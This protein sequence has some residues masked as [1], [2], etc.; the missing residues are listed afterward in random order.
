MWWGHGAT[1]R[2]SVSTRIVHDAGR[3]QATFAAFVVVIF[4]Y[5]AHR[6]VAPERKNERGSHTNRVR[7]RAGGATATEKR[8]VEGGDVTVLLS[9]G[10]YGFQG[11]RAQLLL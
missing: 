7:A 4:L 2:G 8:E 6:T 10:Q 11:L 3:G 9:H 5:S 1:S